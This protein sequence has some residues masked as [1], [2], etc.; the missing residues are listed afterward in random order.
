MQGAIFPTK[1]RSIFKGSFSIIF[2]N[3]NCKNCK[4][5]YFLSVNFLNR[6]TRLGL[7]GHEG[8]RHMYLGVCEGGEQGD[9]SV[10][11]RY[12]GEIMPHYSAT[13]SRWQQI[14]DAKRTSLPMF[15]TLPLLVV[16]FFSTQGTNIVD[17]K[18]TKIPP[19]HHPCHHVLKCPFS[20]L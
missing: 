2:Q 3:K 7:Q 17:K 20:T 15:R 10:C 5:I 11:V 16:F 12:C 19:S 8:I 18:D 4:K 14:F 13:E 9:S 6:I 1:Y